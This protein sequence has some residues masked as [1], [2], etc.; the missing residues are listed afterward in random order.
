METHFTWRMRGNSRIDSKNMIRSPDYSLGL[1]RGWLLN[2]DIPS[3]IRDS[4][5]TLCVSL[6]SSSDVC[7]VKIK[8]DVWEWMRQRYP[9][10]PKGC[11]EQGTHWKVIDV[12]RLEMACKAGL[13][14]E[15]VA[16]ALARDPKTVAYKARDLRLKL[17]KEWAKIIK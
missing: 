5:E 16:E 15:H 13:V 7:E 1:I 3:E 10:N 2:A 11:L 9:M 12:K 8:P 6:E 4:L 17:P 14:L